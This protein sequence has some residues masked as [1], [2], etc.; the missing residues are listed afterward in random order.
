M[1]VMTITDPAMTSEHANK[2]NVQMFKEI[3]K[4]KKGEWLTD[5]CY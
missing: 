4:K 5:M 1:S 3:N 2:F